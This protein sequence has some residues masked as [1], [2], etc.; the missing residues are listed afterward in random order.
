MNTMKVWT[1][2]KTPLTSFSII[3]QSTAKTQQVHTA[4]HLGHTFM[5]V[6][7]THK[8][9]NYGYIVHEFICTRR[10]WN[11]E[12]VGACSNPVDHLYYVLLTGADVYN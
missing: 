7:T 4:G 6:C 3:R 12:H 5:R 2:E 1:L 10:L 8:V 9:H 11:H